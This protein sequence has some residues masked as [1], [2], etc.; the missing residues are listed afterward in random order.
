MWIDFFFF[1]VFWVTLKCFRSWN[2]KYLRKYK[3]PFL[4]NDFIYC[5]AAATQAHLHCVKKQS[6]P[7][8]SHWFWHLLRQQLLQVFVITVIV[9]NITDEEL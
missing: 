3:M 4:K 2:S 1:S 8:H 9:F 6:P 7:R 5:E